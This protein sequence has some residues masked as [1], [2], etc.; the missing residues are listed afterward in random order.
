MSFR[1][2]YLSPAAVRG[3]TRIGDILCPGDEYFPSFSATGCIEHV[4][5]PLEYAPA[6]DIGD[7]SL[8]IS[9]LSYMPQPVLEWVVKQMA[10]SHDSSGPL[11]STFR[12]LDFGLRGIIFGLYYSGRTGVG[13]TGSDTHTLT[14]YTVN[15]VED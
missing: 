7:L 6:A 15:R 13:Y 10:E 1:S 4:D 5:I 11:S 14:G 8:L 3:M 2:Q 9:I 12:Q